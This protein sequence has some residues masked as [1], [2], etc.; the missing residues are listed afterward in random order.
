[1]ATMINFVSYG[2]VQNTIAA[3]VASRYKSA[4]DNSYGGR[5]WS[6]VKVHISLD[7]LNEYLQDILVS[8]EVTHWYDTLI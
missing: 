2:V 8:V 5:Y 1:M 6:S 4:N 7:G 3:P